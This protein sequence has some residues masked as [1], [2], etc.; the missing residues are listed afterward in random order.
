MITGFGWKDEQLNARNFTIANQQGKPNA[1]T[2]TTTIA[3]PPVPMKLE[4]LKEHV[5]KTANTSSVQ[6]PKGQIAAENKAVVKKVVQPVG[7]PKKVQKVIGGRTPKPVPTNDP[8]LEKKYYVRQPTKV[9]PFLHNIVMKPKSICANDT[10]MIILVHSFHPYSDKRMA[11]RETWGKVAQGNANWPNRTI[12]DKM[13]LVFVLGTHKQ[14]G[15]NDK[16]RDEMEVYGDIVQGDFLDDYKNMTLKS[17][18]GLKLVHEECPHTKFMLKSDDDMI[19]NLPY[20]LKIL[21][22]KPYNWT[23]MGPI[24]RGSKVYRSGK[25]KLTK[26]QYPFYTFPQY[27][28]GSAYVFTSDL[29]KPLY[30]TAEYVPS[31]HIDDVYIT[32]VLGRILN[33]T[34]ELRKGFAYWTDKPPSSCDILNETKIAGTKM[35]PAKMRML[36]GQVEKGVCVPTPAP[37]P[38]QKK[39]VPSLSKVA[40][41]KSRKQS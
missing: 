40:K 31:F 4:N 16:I 19:V 17:L 28:A 30:E 32:G 6:E 39:V 38:P 21:H 35:T 7:N 34:H 5:N 13:N 22:E 27:E 11:I 3:V 15:Y 1:T 41:P 9:N 25:W 20:I 10:Y 18:L 29:A 36:W 8:E 23:M 37:P 24:N 33:V 2:K 26:E 12:E 14:N